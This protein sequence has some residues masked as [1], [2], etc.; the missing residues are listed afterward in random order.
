MGKI[1]KRKRN[2]DYTTKNKHLIIFYNGNRDLILD[3]PSLPQKSGNLRV[4][5][6]NA[7]KKLFFYILIT[8]KIFL[9]PPLLR[10]I[11]E[12]NKELTDLNK[13]F[14]YKNKQFEDMS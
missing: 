11:T 5:F 10:E 7:K 3:K 6:V 9:T 8:E 2:I 4:I 13:E 14:T 1:T 12:Q